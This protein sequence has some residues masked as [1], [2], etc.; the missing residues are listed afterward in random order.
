[1]VSP[2]AQAALLQT[3]SY[4]MVALVCWRCIIPEARK[5]LASPLREYVVAR[6]VKRWRYLGAFLTTQFVGMVAGMWFLVLLSMTGAQIRWFQSQADM[7]WCIPLEYGAEIANLLTLFLWVGHFYQQGRKGMFADL[8]ATS[9]GID[10]AVLPVF[11]TIAVP[12]LGTTTVTCSVEATYLASGPKIISFL[13]YVIS[14]IGGGLFL[15]I[16]AFF[17]HAITSCRAYALILFVTVFSG[18]SYL[19]NESA[20]L[21][22]PA[23]RSWTLLEAIQSS[24]LDSAVGA[25]AMFGLA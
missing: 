21:F 22:H 24:P 7:D 13:L 10:G 6:Y 18:V 14:G 4:G 1:M 12:V 23:S 25:A 20:D 9:S 19:G 3:A 11:W 15:L 5:A 17:S 16:L 8:R 2:T